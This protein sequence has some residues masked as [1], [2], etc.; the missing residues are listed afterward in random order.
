MVKTCKA[1]LLPRELLGALKHEGF[2]TETL[3][4]S[5]QPGWIPPHSGPRLVLSPA[6]GSNPS[7]ALPFSFVKL[8]KC[9]K[10]PNTR[11]GQSPHAGPSQ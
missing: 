6:L 3:G 9:P 8:A 7:G 10:H 5:K 11:G 2:L 4:S 1:L